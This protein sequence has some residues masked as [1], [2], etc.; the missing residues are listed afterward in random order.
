MKKPEKKWYYDGLAFSCKG[1]GRCCSGPD[2]GYV[3][4]SSEEI[5]AIA[6]YLNLT[7]EAFKKQ[8]LR[9]VGIRHSLL[10]NELDKD[11]IF[12]TRTET[13]K[14][15]RIYPVRP[16]QCRTWPFWSVNLQSEKTWQFA[17]Q[18]CPGIDLDQ[19]Y[20]FQTI[21]QIRTGKLDSLTP[22]GDLP[23]AAI[24]WIRLHLQDAPRLEFI[25]NIYNQLDRHLEAANPH[26]DSCG[27]CCRFD[28]YDHK[29]FATTLEMLYFFHGLQTLQENG[30][31]KNIRANPHACPFLFKAGCQIRDW[32][33]AGSRYCFCQSLNRVFQSDLSESILK[34]LRSAHYQIG[35]IYLYADLRTWLDLW[36]QTVSSS[37]ST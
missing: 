16:R 6:E 32:R 20:D 34:Q 22:C 4:V 35:A 1:C 31:F 7:P 5:Q 12:L 14:G 24:Q 28:D 29:L 15:C 23:R 19:Y 18:V 8:C 30:I 10:E 17:G 21:E 13:G 25:Q 37:Q 33:T 11:C 9:R 27:K 3:W 26:C 2:E 36:C